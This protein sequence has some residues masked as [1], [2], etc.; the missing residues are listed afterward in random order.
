MVDV[1]RTPRVSVIVIFF[2]EAR[3]LTEAIESVRAQSFGDW[4][5]ILVDDGST[6]G[7]EEMAQR[8]ADGERIR[9]ICHPDHAN[10]GMSA[11]RNTGLA[12]VRGEFITFLDA[13]D[14]WPL[15]KLAEQVTVF[16]ATPQAD[17]VY[18]RARIW[19]E[20][21]QG[22]ELKDYFYDLGVAP[23]MLYPPGALLPLLIR[24][25]AQTPM[26]GNAMMRRTLVERVGGF[27][28]RFPGMF[29]DQVFF[30]KTHLVSHCHVD[31]RIWLF[32]RQHAASCTAQSAGNVRDLLARHRFLRW[33]NA[34][35]RAQKAGSFKIRWEIVRARMALVEGFARLGVRWLL[36]RR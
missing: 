25:K 11:S 34:Y 6:D 22:A 5:L 26:S 21:E 17:M 36:G 20:W 29:E 32:Y 10:R 24:N 19:H 9:Y 23:G 13:D 1:T 18:G 33:L 28:D 2:N 7:S 3:F 12:A 27:D 30:A 14:V 8:A 31:D 15:H 4:E 16:D 35:V